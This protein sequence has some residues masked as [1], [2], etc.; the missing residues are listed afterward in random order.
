MKKY[1][2]FLIILVVTTA[3]GQLPNTTEQSA[4]EV[5]PSATAPPVATIV[6]FAQ[7]VSPL[8]TPTPTGR[9]DSAVASEQISP[10]ATPI[11][12]PK[13]TLATEIGGA[14]SNKLQAANTQALVSQAQKMVLKFIDDPAL[15]IEQVA[16]QNVEAMQWRDSSLGCPRKGMMYAQV[17]TP[18]YLIELEAEGKVYEFHTDTNRAVVLCAVDGQRVTQ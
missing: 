14:M 11:P 4:A 10:L 9:T 7:P 13:G 16:V 1:L 18:G 2:L 6:E 8:P 17:I 3:C 12:L 15:T 5:V